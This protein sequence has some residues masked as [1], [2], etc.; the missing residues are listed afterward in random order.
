MP[1]DFP[2]EFISDPMFEF[3]KARNLLQSYVRNYVDKGK[4][5]LPIGVVDELKTPTQKQPGQY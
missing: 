5:P 4:I 2:Q 3:N 1:V